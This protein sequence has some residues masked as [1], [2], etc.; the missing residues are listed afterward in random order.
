MNLCLPPSKTSKRLY[1][2]KSMGLEVDED[3]ITE[4]VDEHHEVVLDIGADLRPNGLWG[5]YHYPYCKN[6]GG[7]VECGKAISE[8]NDNTLWIYE[9]SKAMYPS[10]YLLEKEGVE[11]R[12]NMALGRILESQ[13]LNKMISNPIAIFTYCWYRYHEV[14]KFITPEDIIN[15]IGLSKDQHLDGSVIWGSSSDLNTEEK[16]LQFQEYVDTVFG[17]LVKNIL[18]IPESRLKLALRSPRLMKEIISFAT[19]QKQ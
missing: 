4:L 14:E 8:M 10:I 13:R 17:P 6:H 18:E 11:G 15:T 9:A 3:D 5:Y 16:C 19:K 1:L 12:R 2:C 7:V